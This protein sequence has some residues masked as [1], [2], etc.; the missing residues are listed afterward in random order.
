MSVAVVTDSTAYLPAG[1]GIT[2]VPLTV[3][4]NGVEGR[5]GLDAT[6]AEVARALS[7]RR[8][9]VTTSRPSPEV[10]VSTYRRLLDAGATGVV[11][12]HLSAEL[13]GTFESATLAAAQ[14]G[15]RLAV[16]DAQSTGMGLGFPALAAA[17]AAAE[18]ADL[19]GVRG[20][21][22]DAIDRTTT[23]LYVDTLEFLR[24]GGRIGAASALLGTALS[25][26]PILLVS[27]GAIVVRDKVRTPSRGVAR[28]VELAVETTAE[29]DVDIAVHHLGAAERA[30]A[31]AGALGERLGE[32]LHERYITEVGAVVAAH[33]G[34]GLFGVVVH[35]RA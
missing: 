28:L 34:P 4:I 13:S 14:V 17:A 9:A 3:V 5:E 7:A 6:S 31:L 25:V 24:R 26:K 16:V 20:A 23:L 29:S 18:G 12:V 11:S 27:K 32:R 21:A 30:A 22:A 15:E 1:H 19:D 33:V 10:F 2:V 35:R 8:V